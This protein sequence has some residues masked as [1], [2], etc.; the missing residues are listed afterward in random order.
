MALNVIL[1]NFAILKIIRRLIEVSKNRFR[2]SLESNWTHSRSHQVVACLWC[3]IEKQ[4]R[5][6]LSKVHLLRHIVN[7][8]RRF[9]T[10]LNYETE[11]GEQF[12]KHIWEHLCFTNRLNNSID[13]ANKFAKQAIMQHIRRW[14]LDLP[15]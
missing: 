12:N 4:S 1:G 6:L 8:M 14:L 10:I 2:D 13:I 7:D 3:S 5:C 15:W 11:E 9:D